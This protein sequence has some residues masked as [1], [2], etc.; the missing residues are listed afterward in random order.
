MGE[1]NL[2]EHVAGEFSRDVTTLRDLVSIEE[3][4]LWKWKNDH[5]CTGALEVIADA[6]VYHDITVGATVYITSIDVEVLTANKDCYFEL[7]YTSAVGAGGAFT[8]LT[9]FYFLDRG[10][11]SSAGTLQHRI[12]TMPR[13]VTQDAAHRCI[14]YRIQGA[15]ASTHVLMAWKGWER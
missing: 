5:T 9:P 14:T 15:D 8:A 7:G 12:W 2:Y 10:A 13:K 6:L 11:A 3:L 1:A 4:D